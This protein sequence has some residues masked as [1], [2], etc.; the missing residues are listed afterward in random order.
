MPQN[1]SRPARVP[2]ATPD[3]VHL[4]GRTGEVDRGDARHQRVA[5]G[6]RGVRVPLPGEVEVA[7]RVH[8]HVVEDD[9]VGGGAVVGPVHARRG[10]LGAVGLEHVDPGGRDL[11]AAE[12]RLERAHEHHAPLGV[13]RHGVDRADVASARCP[14]VEPLAGQAVLHRDRPDVQLVELAAHVHGRALHLD[15][16]AGVADAESGDRPLPDPLAV[17]VDLD[18]HH[19]PDAHVAAA[20][21]GDVGVA[22]RVGG[23]GPERVVPG[24]RHDVL[25][26]EL[27]GGRVLEQDGV[28]VAG[29][30]AGRARDVDGARRRHGEAGGAVCEVRRSVPALLPQDGPVGAV[31]DEVDVAA[32]LSRRYRPRRGS[33]PCRWR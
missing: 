5:L 26:L 19:R 12:T 13:D 4:E 7:A 33:S 10:Q 20:L 25:P 21:P 24:G 22:L 11:A 27:A 2:V 28:V 3:L 18:G 14:G 1:W 8:G 23:D 29:V 15:E 17:G 31:L 9:G 16:A 30:L 32:R 6:P